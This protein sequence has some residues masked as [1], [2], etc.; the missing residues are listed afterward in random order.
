[1]AARNKSTVD[2]YV[3]ENG[4]YETTIRAESVRVGSEIDFAKTLM[5]EYNIANQAAIAVHE[6]KS[7]EFQVRAA[8]ATER[9]RL[10]AMA[11]IENAKVKL[12]AGDGMARTAISAAGIYGQMANAALGGMNTLVSAATA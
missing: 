12:S 6:A 9:G 5:G 10:A 8:N 2:A 7:R 4:A 3:A 1:M 11:L